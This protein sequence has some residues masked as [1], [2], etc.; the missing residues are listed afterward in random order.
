[1]FLSMQHCGLTLEE[2]FLGVTYNAA[3]SLKKDNKIGLIKECY[4][5]DMI[6]WDIKELD[7]IPYWLDSSNTKIRKIMKSGKI[8]LSNH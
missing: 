7:E 2:S 6:F 3:K 4:N 1:M 8:L 5:A